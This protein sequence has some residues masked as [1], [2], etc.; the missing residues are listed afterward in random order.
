[1]HEPH[2]R[3]EGFGFDETALFS[4]R[5]IAVDLDLVTKIEEVDTCVVREASFRR[6]RRLEDFVIVHVSLKVR[7]SSFGQCPEST[8]NGDSICA[9]L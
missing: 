6:V 9:G 7:P 2:C 1:M 3:E 8:T 4:R 5:H